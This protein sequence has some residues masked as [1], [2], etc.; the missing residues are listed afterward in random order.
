MKVKQKKIKKNSKRNIFG[1]LTKL[2]IPLSGASFL[3][4]L[5]KT[6]NYTRTESAVEPGASSLHMDYAIL[7]F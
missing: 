5:S 1:I 7:E 6:Y 4:A 2:I 3:P